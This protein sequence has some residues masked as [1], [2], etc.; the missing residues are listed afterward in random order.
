MNSEFYQA[1][2]PLTDIENE[3]VVLYQWFNWYDTQNIQYN[4]D[5][6]LYGSSS[7]DLS[8]LD[9]EAVAKAAR[10]KE[11]KSA[12]EEEIKKRFSQN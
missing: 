10:I 2:N 7:I 1:P 8:E 3:L 6:R 5:L 9:Q 12:K 11:L 4:R